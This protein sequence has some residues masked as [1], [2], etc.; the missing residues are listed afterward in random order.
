VAGSVQD[1]VPVTVPADLVMWYV[2]A[3]PLQKRKVR[4]TRA[5]LF[6][7]SR[8]AGVRRMACSVQS[9]ERRC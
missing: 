4:S 7:A 9:G 8:K 5:S 3:V 2:T 6:R 1:V